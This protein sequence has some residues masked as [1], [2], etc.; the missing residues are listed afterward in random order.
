[1]TMREKYANIDVDNLRIERQ[2]EQIYCYEKRSLATLN[3]PVNIFEIFLTYICLIIEYRKKITIFF[4]CR[5]CIGLHVYP[6]N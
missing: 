5:N 2:N 3:K 6:L 4:R 1:M